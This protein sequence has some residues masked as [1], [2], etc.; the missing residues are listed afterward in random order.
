MAIADFFK[1]LARPEVQQKLAAM[2][3]AYGPQ[4]MD[5]GVG[6]RFANYEQYRRQQQEDLLRQQLISERLRAQQEEE[7]RAREEEQRRREAQAKLEQQLRAQDLVASLPSAEADMAGTGPTHGAMAP[8]QAILPSI[9]QYYADIG[10]YE[11]SIGLRQDAASMAAQ[12]QQEAQREALIQQTLSDPTVRQRLGPAAEYILRQGGASV[13]KL[14]ATPP[15]PP[16][17]AGGPVGPGAQGPFAGKAETERL[18]NVVY[19]LGPKA[20]A[21]TITPEEKRALD[22][23][24]MVLNTGLQPRDPSYPTGNIM[25]VFGQPGAPT[26]AAP[27]QAPAA[28]GAP[29]PQPTAEGQRTPLGPSLAQVAGD[30]VGP[31]NWAQRKLREAPIP[32]PGRDLPGNVEAQEAAGLANRLATDLSLRIQE[33]PQYP[34]KQRK[35]LEEKIVRLDPRLWSNEA[36]YRTELVETARYVAQQIERSQETLKKNVPRETRAAALTNLAVLPDVMRQLG[37]HFAR[38]EAEMDATLQ[39]ALPGE[40]IVMVD[41]QG[42]TRQYVVGED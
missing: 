32:L 41:E 38:S 18:M 37:V 7:Q 2:S 33:N 6:A 14:L 27:G 34:E 15:A 20:Q 21:G 28:P 19:A 1:A 29:S 3:Y 17:G 10:D 12:Q 31:V 30:V 42:K 11:R 5:N 25:D 16:P 26:A 35:I 24:V 36:A 23:A 9:A 13:P 22:M 4:A 40:I 8:P 39:R